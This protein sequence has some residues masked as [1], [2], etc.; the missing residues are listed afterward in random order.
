MCSWM[1]ARANL[2]DERVKVEYERGYKTL[3]EF[4][5]KYL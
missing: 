1:A 4:F 5:A 2:D 3:L